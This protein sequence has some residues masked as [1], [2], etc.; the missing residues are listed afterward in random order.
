[1]PV[2]FSV[3]ILLAVSL[4]ECSRAQCHSS[5]E[6]PMALG[7]KRAIGA[8]LACYDPKRRSPAPSCLVS[9][10]QVKGL[11]TTGSNAAGDSSR[12]SVQPRLRIVFAHSS[13]IDDRHA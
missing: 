9:A 6:K 12:Q 11:I 4:K 10:N 2:K 3:F 1:M 13:L 7:A 5:V 8:K